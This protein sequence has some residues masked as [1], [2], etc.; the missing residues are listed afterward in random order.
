M[1]LFL[2]EALGLSQATGFGVAPY[3]SFRAGMAMLTALLVSFLLGPTFIRWLQKKQLGQ[4]VRDDGPKTH[5]SKSGTPTMGGALILFAVLGSGLLW[6]DLRNRYCWYVIGITFFYGLMGFMDDYLKI[7]K[8]NTQGLS[9]RQKLG[10]QFLIGISF[11]GFE[12]F[13]GAG[14]S[15]LLFPFLKDL[16]FD[17]GIL[18]VGFGALVISG[19]SNG[20]NLTDG[21]DGLAIG[22]IMIN[23]ACLGILGYLTGNAVFAEYLNYPFLAG[24]GELAIFAAALVG[25]GLGFL[26]YNTYPAQVFMGD[27]G[28]LPLGAA[29]GALAVF[30]KHEILLLILGGVFLVEGLSVIAQVTSFKLTGKRIFRMAP[31]HH[32]FEL[33]GW[34]EPKVIVRF[35]IISIIL[36]LISLL[37]VKLR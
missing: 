11:C 4:Q 13:Y 18:Y 5:L 24:T 14:D 32:H 31:I 36:A 37:S 15:N 2:V 28:S 23:A 26:W 33:K 34:P 29:I 1:I 27:T 7:A 30:T 10:L 17:L 20:V 16:S 22:P 35:W 3:I 21:L 25:A 19:T 12:Y 9:A 8:K 6:M